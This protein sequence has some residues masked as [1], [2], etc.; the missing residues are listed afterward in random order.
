MATSD[1]VPMLQ[2]QNTVLVI[3][4]LSVLTMLNLLME[5]QT[6]M[7]G[8]R[9]QQLAKEVP[10]ALKWIFGKQT[11]CHLLLLFIP[12]IYQVSTPAPLQ[13]SVEIMT[14]VTME[15]VIRMVVT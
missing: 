4:T 10:V 1:K 14:S 7:V 3:A 6:S 8:T 11:P 15:F 9:L 5:R 2:A 13:L 12:A